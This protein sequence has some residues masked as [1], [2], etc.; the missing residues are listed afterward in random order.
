MK[1]AKCGN[2]DKF[3][4]NQAVRGTIGVI[5]DGKG[6]FLENIGKDGSIEADGLDFDNPE[7]PFACFKCQTPVDDMS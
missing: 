4:G 1:C 7:G 6:D 3:F 5:V 2:T